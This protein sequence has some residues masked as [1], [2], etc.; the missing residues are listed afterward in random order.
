MRNN[1]A[2]AAATE[3]KPG[4][5]PQFDEIELHRQVIKDFF[6]E[7]KIDPKII[8]GIFA[9]PTAL[10]SQKRRPEVAMHEILFEEL[11]INPVI[12]ETMY[13]GGA[14]YGLMIQ[15]AAMAIAEGRAECILCVSAGK[16]P[17]VGKNGG[18]T[19][20]K[21]V[22][23]P[24]FEFI[25][26]S[27]IPPMY[28]FIAQ[29]YMHEF[30][31]TQEQLASV[32]VSSR[33]W[34]LK[35]P[36]ALMKDKG[37]IDIDDVLSSRVISTP[38]HL[39]DCSVPCE[40]GAAIL[41]TSEKIAKKI[42]N[43]PAYILGMGEIHGDTHISQRRNFSTYGSTES[44]KQA[45]NMAGITHRDIDVV[46]FYDSFS[47]NPIIYLE[48]F[49]FCEKGKGGA[50]VMEGNTSPGGAL[51]MNTYGG[52]LSFGHTGDSSGMSMIVEGALQT[53]GIA[54]ERQVKD[55]N[56]VLVHSHGGMMSEHS[57]LIL[58]R[59]LS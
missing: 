49:G 12:S 3:M 54:R 26:G 59:Q 58:G 7:W 52:L 57:T 34:A 16:F 29:R 53:M 46:E 9:A 19:T 27:Y 6:R 15:R 55:A 47:I 1:P 11:M 28:A 17:K 25:Y 48:E 42:S 24:E 2:I 44:G 10:F 36:N 45:F 4:R 22:S 32:A 21:V 31:T 50:Y 43:Q 5:Y 51:P 30:G 20:A 56:L 8:D 40:G 18:E 37:L 41:V 13:A 14:T 39:L 38:F 33:E 35:H 23:H